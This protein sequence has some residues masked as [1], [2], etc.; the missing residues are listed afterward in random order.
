MQSKSDTRQRVLAFICAYR[1]KHGGSPSFAEI[2]T[3]L[4]FKSVD[5]AVYHVKKLVAFGLLTKAPGKARAFIPVEIAQPKLLK[6]QVFQDEDL[7]KVLAAVNHVLATGGTLH[8]P[9][10]C[11]QGL[12]LAKVPRTLYT[13][14]VV[15][16]AN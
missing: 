7:L 12:T 3:E 1:A 11:G 13:Q 14:A 16:A 5:T 9:L 6:L 15:V 8:G 4:R 10:Q 2:A